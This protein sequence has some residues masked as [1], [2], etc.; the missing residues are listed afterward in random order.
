MRLKANSPGD[1]YVGRNRSWIG[2]KT[3]FLDSEH[4]RWGTVRLHL[5]RLGELAEP[6]VEA[7]KLTLVATLVETSTIERSHIRSLER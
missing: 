6:H 1:G 2:C 4:S 7:A 3:A 5:D